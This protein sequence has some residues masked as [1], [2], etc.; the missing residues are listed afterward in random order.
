MLPFLMENDS[1]ENLIC[2]IE[3]YDAHIKEHKETAEVEREPLLDHIKRTDSYF[4]LLW[5]QKYM[6]EMMERFYEQVWPDITEEGKVFLMETIQGI[7]SFHDLGRVNSEFQKLAMKNDRAGKDNIFP[8]IGSRHSF[9]SSI[10]YLDYYMGELRKQ[11]SEKQDRIKIK[12]Y[13]FLNAY[14][15]SRHHSDLTNFEEFL[16]ALEKGSVKEIIEKGERESY[17]FYRRDFCLNRKKLGSFVKEIKKTRKEKQKNECYTAEY[18]YVKMLYSLLVASDYYATSEFMTGRPVCQLGGRDF[19]KEM[20][21][22]Y[23]QTDMMRGIRE[24]QKNEYL[25][26]EKNIQEEREINRLRTEMLCD[27]E[28][29]FMQ[30]KSDNLFYLEAPT[31]SGK[32]NTSMNLTFQMIR[33]DER[34]QKLFY[35]Y[36]FN[37]LVEQN[38]QSMQETFAK[39]EEILDEIAVVNSIT[40]IKLSQKKKREEENTE[41]TGYYQDALL[42]RQFL[43]YPV[44]LSTHVSLFHTMF[45]DSKESAFGFHQLANS[46]IVLDEIQSYKNTIWGEIICFLKEYAYLLNIKIIIMSATLPNLDLLSD[47]MFPAVRLIEEREKYFSHPKFKERVRVSYELLEADDVEGQLLEHIKESVN[48]KRKI[49][50]EFIKKSTAQDFFEMLKAYEAMVCPIEYMSGEDSIMERSRILDS[51]EKTTGA[52]VLVATQVIEAGVD[53]DMDEGY[54]NI[55]K[56]DSEEQ[57]LGRINRSGKKKGKVYFFQLDEGKKIYGEDVRIEQP[58]TL[59]NVE[60]REY[61]VNKDFSSYYQKILEVVRRN[62]MEQVGEA[63]IK[64]FFLHKVG[65]M[66]MSD[67]KEHMALIQDDQ[68]NMPVYL[69]R[70]TNGE[71]GEKIDGAQ[72]WK[73]YVELLKNNAMEY[74]EKKVKLSEITSKMNGFIYQIKRNV[75]L[76][77]NDKVG[78]IFYIENGEKYFQNGKLNRKMIQGELGDFVDFI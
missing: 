9:V 13:I 74:A 63:G 52:F 18:I 38:K 32:S 60:I 35:I 70:V 64:D 22:I 29:V 20:S 49:L 37:T 31:G 55:S 75:D 30:H 66:R 44:I 2:N 10:F 73:K 45:G 17:A 68:W 47:E 7:S 15:I 61:L 41:A 65:G 1:M 62:Y 25:D 46:V 33:T 67:V 19:I 27:S 51:I 43:N 72:L 11:V 5:K 40:P 78:E 3:N 58:F 34:L 16:R 36:P 28:K 71:N 4:Q 26:V 8:G 69:A 24:Y 53:I 21:A 59:K 23:E 57:F 14:I 76:L 77:Y 56:L 39:K 6:D 42:D 54:K 50:I 48:A 12:Y